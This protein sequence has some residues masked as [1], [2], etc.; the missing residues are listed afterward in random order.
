MRSILICHHDAPLDSEGL[1]GWMSSFTDVVGVVVIEENSERKKK[2]VKRELERVGK[3]RFADVMAFRLYYKLRLA[4]R[5]ATWEQDLLDELKA[6]WPGDGSK[7]P[8]ILRTHSPNSDE[9]RDFIAA[10]KPDIMIAR[11]K[12]I[13]K[14]SVFTIPTVGTFVMHPG[15]CPEYRNAHG[16][17]WALAQDDSDKVGTTLLKID[18]GVDTGPVYAYYSYDYDEVHESHIV[19]QQ[20]TLF[21]NL[22]KVSEKLIE[23]AEGDGKTGTIDTKGRS[24]STWGQPWL[25]K[26]LLWKLK[27]RMRQRAQ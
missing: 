22:D 13:L 14:K 2:R 8:P 18:A 16:G 21:D 7:P 23:I 24:S 12:F 20:R 19:I 1:V 26:Y 17:F 4:Q 10:A 3:L 27:A 25:S 15:I 9:A 6:R 5:D 11:C